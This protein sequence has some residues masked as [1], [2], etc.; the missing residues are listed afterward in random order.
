[1]AAAQDAGYSTSWLIVL[2]FGLMASC[3][4]S[5][6][7]VDEDIDYLE[8]NKLDVHY[9]ETGDSH[10]VLV[11]L[12]G[13]G[14]TRDAYRPFAEHAADRGAVVFNVEWDVVPRLW[15]DALEQAGC[16]VRYAKG[17]AEEYGGDPDR[18]VLVG[19]S[20][21]A[22][23]AGRV[24]TDGEA[25]DLHCP[26]GDS[27]VPRALALV[28][29]SQAPGGPGPWPRATLTG[30]PNLRIAVIHGQG[31]VVIPPR[32]S[33]ATAQILDQQGYDVELYLIPGGHYDIL[34]IDPFPSPSGDRSE[35]TEVNPEE[36]IDIIIGLAG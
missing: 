31:D 36:A 2:L 23:F 28:A 34:G 1:M 3:A 29:P 13:A 27:A 8:A 19:H 9:P 15:A 21:G 20:S 18:V 14:L 22:V 32:V 4:S 26:G 24:A 5:G 11:I 6:V 7:A 30:D 10:P 17:H 35:S 33:V 25:L 16:A 12:H